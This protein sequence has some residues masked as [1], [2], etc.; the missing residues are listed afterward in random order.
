[1]ENNLNQ[2]QAN[3]REANSN[4]PQDKEYSAAASKFIGETSLDK[5]HEIAEAARM[6]KMMEPPQW[7]IPDEI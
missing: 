2:N 3:Q 5:M 4:Q 6:K 1:M 7:V